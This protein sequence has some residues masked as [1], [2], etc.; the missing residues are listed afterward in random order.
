MYV[1]SW[2]EISSAFLVGL[3]VCLSVC[4][5][6]CLSACLFP[7]L[8]LLFDAMTATPENLQTILDPG[9]K[10]TI[11]Y[12]KIIKEPQQ[13]FRGHFTDIVDIRGN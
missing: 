9:P 5:S 4:L 11:D 6:A 12:N 13:L 1:L 2:S 10:A 3:S 7:Y 8:Y